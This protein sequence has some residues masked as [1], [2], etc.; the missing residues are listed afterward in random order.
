MILYQILISFHVIVAVVGVGQSAALAL[1]TSARG[2]S[3]A[4]ALLMRLIRVGS[5]SLVLMLASCGLL[6]WE[7]EGVFANALW[8]RVSVILFFVLGFLYSQASRLLKRAPA[9][10]IGADERRML[11]TMSC[12]MCV[13]IAVLSALMEVK[14]WG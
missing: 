11:F 6:I 14:P 12:A 1:L 2:S 8:M 9:E 5:W 13:L 4:P 10:G 3:P 7:T